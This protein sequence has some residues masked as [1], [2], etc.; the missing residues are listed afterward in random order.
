V[1]PPQTKAV[2]PTG[3]GDAL[4]AGILYGFQ[5]GWKFERCLAFG[6]AAGASNAQVWDVA[7]LGLQDIMDME[8]RVRIQRA[9]P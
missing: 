6:T 4:V 2:N 1:T 5:H 7:T 9:K 3:S 8:P